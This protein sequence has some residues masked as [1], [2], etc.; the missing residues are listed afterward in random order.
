MMF[1]TY[2]IFWKNIIYFIQLNLFFQIQK[3]DLL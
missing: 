2:K 3:I 1:K